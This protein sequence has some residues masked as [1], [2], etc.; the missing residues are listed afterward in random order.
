MRVAHDRRMAS[1]AWAASVRD[2]EAGLADPLHGRVE[3]LA[4][5]REPSRDPVGFTAAREPRVAEVEGQSD[6]LEP[7][8]A[9]GSPEG[10]DAQVVPQLGV[11]RVVVERVAE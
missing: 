8:R 6:E 11:H 4:R 10:D 7:G 9:A 5:A 1:A 3:L 2:R